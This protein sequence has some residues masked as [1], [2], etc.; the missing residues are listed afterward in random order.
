[1]LFNNEKNNNALELLYGFTQIL[2]FA[3]ILILS[4]SIFITNSYIEQTHDY[5]SIGYQIL[6]FGIMVLYLF[7]FRTIDEFKERLVEFAKNLNFT[8]INIYIALLLLLISVLYFGD[9]IFYFNAWGDEVDQLNQAAYPRVNIPY[10]SEMIQMPPVDFYLTAASKVLFGWNI[11]GLRF[12]ILL[13]MI[14]FTLLFIGTLISIFEEHF[15]KISAFIIVFTGPVFLSFST[16]AR[17]YVLASFLVLAI[18]IQIKYLAHKKDQISNKE[19]LLFLSTCSLLSFTLFIQ[20]QLV[21]LFLGSLLCL[22]LPF[23]YSK[24]IFLGLT[25]IAML[26]LPSVIR[27]PEISRDKGIFHTNQ[28]LLEQIFLYFLKP[29]NLKQAIFMYSPFLEVFIF[30]ISLL[31]VFIIIRSK[32]VRYPK[33]TISLLLTPFIITFSC[34]FLMSLVSDFVFQPRFSFVTYPLI[35]ILI[36]CSLSKIHFEKLIHNRVFKFLS[37]GLLLIIIN[38]AINHGGWKAAHEYHWKKDSGKLYSYFNKLGKENTVIGFMPNFC[39]IGQFCLENF[40]A[41][42]LFTYDKPKNV[43]Y[44]RELDN[45]E[46]STWFGYYHLKDLE[47]FMNKK[48]TD[49]AYVIVVLRIDKLKRLSPKPK[50][51]QKLDFPFGN[52]ITLKHKYATEDEFLIYEI[53][54]NGNV[55]LALEQLAL[56]LKNFYGSNAALYSFYYP[57]IEYSLRNKDI[58]K[59]EKYIELSKNLLFSHTKSGYTDNLNYAE[60][61]K[62]D[63]LKKDKRLASLRSED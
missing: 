33:V 8:N 32:K 20:G 7:C 54:T 48:I 45:F 57:I 17:P 19:I 34:I 6:F 11:Y 4:L 27:I 23:K 25:G 30:I 2:L 63:I 58:T 37:F 15:S 52:R 22:I 10:S 44:I 21:L 41:A 9:K 42:D 49:P 43:F 31:A 18:L 38:I 62:A 46:N 16:M 47:E 13:A 35:T 50:R 12:S 1:M 29:F 36:F 51:L 40:I 61:I 28:S 24:K 3:F 39:T 56:H 60:F 59:A 53:K 5:I 14:L 55:I 26:C